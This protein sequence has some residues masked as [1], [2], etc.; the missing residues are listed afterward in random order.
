MSWSTKNDGSDEMQVVQ[1]FRVPR[2]SSHMLVFHEA[3][4][5]AASSPEPMPR[6]WNPRCTPS[7]GQHQGTPLPTPKRRV[8]TRGRRAMLPEP[9]HPFDAPTTPRTSMYR[10][11]AYG[12][13]DQRVRAMS[14]Q[15]NLYIAEGM[16][17]CAGGCA[18]RSLVQAT[19]PK[20]LNA[21]V[22]DF[23]FVANCVMHHT[24]VA[25]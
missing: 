8:N 18:L 20:L 24:G 12:R 14:R 15:A 11:S 3:G 10:P 1:N 21:S 25:C 16:F 23:D 4:R 9:A 2:C 22:D 7:H 19:A 13:A 5:P 17:V 6:A